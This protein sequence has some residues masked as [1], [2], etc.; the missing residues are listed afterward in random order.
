[1]VAAAVDRGAGV[2][3]AAVYVQIDGGPF[4]EASFRDGRVRAGTSGLSRGRHRITFHVSDRQEAKNMENVLRVL[5]NTTSL[6]TT[7]VV[8]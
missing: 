7:F 8:R 6:S 1:V 4:R 5:P 3:P 2:D